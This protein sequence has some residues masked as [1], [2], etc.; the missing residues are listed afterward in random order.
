[1]FLSHKAFVM[2]ASQL[3][4]IVSKLYSLLFGEK[5]CGCK[6]WQI[7]CGHLFCSWWNCNY[8]ESTHFC[9]S[10]ICI[11][12]TEYFNGAERRT[13]YKIT[14]MPEKT[15]LI[16]TNYKAEVFKFENTLIKELV[17]T[18]SGFIFTDKNMRNSRSTCCCCCSF[19]F[20]LWKYDI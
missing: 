11:T 3:Q 1:M 19:G 16:I 4:V 9:F 5:I 6:F 7:F 15:M 14:K 13:L 20:I 10:H 2:N 8:S 12:S 17:K 18:S